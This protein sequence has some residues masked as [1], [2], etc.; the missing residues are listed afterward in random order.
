MLNTGETKKIEPKK[1][2]VPI[3]V[4]LNKRSQYKSPYVTRSGR[5]VINP[6]R[7]LHAVVNKID[8]NDPGWIKSMN[9]ELEKFRS[10]DVYEEVPIPTGVKPISMGWVHT[11][12]IDS[13]KGVVRKSRCV[14]HG[15]R[16]KEKLIM[17]LLVLVH[18]L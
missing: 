10:K 14:V 13:L 6:K 18:L 11:E 1:R 16:Q 3:T 9:A 2:E 17:T 5:T 15:N 12:K 7:Y 4:K 8:Y